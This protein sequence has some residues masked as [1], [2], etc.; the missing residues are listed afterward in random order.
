L[1]DSV[2]IILA[3]QPYQ[4]VRIL[5]RAEPPTPPAPPRFDDSNDLTILQIGSLTTLPVSTDVFTSWIG[6]SAGF[7]RDG[8]LTGFSIASGAVLE[9]GAKLQVWVIR[10][11]SE[12]PTNIFD[13]YLAQH[14]ATLGEFDISSLAPTSSAPRMTFEGLFVPVKKHDMLAIRC[15]Q[16][17][18]LPYATIKGEVNEYTDSFTASID[19]DD[20]TTGAVLGVVEFTNLNKFGHV[21]HSARVTGSTAQ[22]AAEIATEDWE[23]PEFSLSRSSAGV[24]QGNT[25]VRTLWSEQPFD[26][27]LTADLWDGLDDNGNVA[28]SGSYTIKL[29]DASGMV[30]DWLGPIGNSS[31]YDGPGWH[32][33]DIA[34]GMAITSGGKMYIAAGYNEAF[35]SMFRTTTAN[36]QSWAY[37][38]GFAHRL[39]GA[40]SFHVCTDNTK[41]YWA[42]GKPIDGITHI[43]ANNVSDDNAHTFSSGTNV[44]YS[45]RTYSGASVV[46]NTDNVSEINYYGDGLP[47]G[48][49]AQLTGDLMFLSRGILNQ[50]H[51]LNKNTGAAVATINSF[52]APTRMC[53][54]PISDGVWLVT[55]PGANWQ[56]A[57]YSVNAGTGAFTL[58]GG[59]EITSADEILAISTSPDG[60]TIRIACGGASQQI[61]SYT[62]GADQLG[63]SG[64]FA[65]ATGWTYVGSGSGLVIED[66][67]LKGNGT[68]ADCSMRFSAAGLTSGKA[69]LVEWDI[70]T[71]TGGSTSPAVIAVGTARSAVG[72]YREWRTANSNLADM[73]TF[74]FNGTVDNFIIREANVSVSTFGLAG[75]YATNGPLVAFNKF[76]F[77]NDNRITFRP[78]PDA[79]GTAWTYLAHQADG[80]LWVGDSFNRRNLRYSI[81]GT[82]FTH[83]YTLEWGASNYSAAIDPANATRVFL[84]WKEYAVD[85]SKRNGQA[86]FY[87]LVANYGWAIADD[88]NDQYTRARF[89]RTLSNGRTYCFPRSYASGSKFMEL[90]STGLRDT[91]VTVGGFTTVGFAA[92]GN[93]VRHIP[94]TTGNPHVFD[95]RQLTGFDGSNNPQHAAFANFVTSAVTSEADPKELHAAV[96]PIWTVTT[97]GIIPAYDHRKA[98]TGVHIA[99]IDASTG[100]FLWRALPSTPSNRFVQDSLPRARMTNADWAVDHFDLSPSAQSGTRCE[101]IGV[102]IIAGFNGEGWGAGQTNKYW[103]Y[104][105]SGLMAGCFGPVLEGTG[106]GQYGMAG[107]AIMWG[108]SRLDANTFILAHCDESVYGGTH[109]WKITGDISLTIHNLNVTWNAANYA[110]NV[111]DTKNLLTGLPYNASIVNGVGGWTR[112]PATDV[113]DNSSI[114]PYFIARTNEWQFDSRAG[115]TL[116]PGHTALPD[117]VVKA[118]YPSGTNTVSVTRTL[119]SVGAQW[120]LSGILQWRNADIGSA[121]SPFGY[122][123]IEILDAADKIIARLNTNETPPST[124][125][126]YGNGSSWEDFVTAEPLREFMQ[127]PKRMS[128]ARNAAGDIVFNYDTLDEFVVAPLDGTANAAVPAKLRVQMFFSA[129]GT[130]ARS[131]NF[132]ELRID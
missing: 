36:P 25:L 9:A 21:L 128:I 17:I 104:H 23:L 55:K 80:K 1:A 11:R 38:M 76:G 28:S 27:N 65:S 108:L 121:A 26:G 52:T 61:K 49:A 131:L 3:G 126:I 44:V 116:R 83:D 119:P 45:G 109:V 59:T 73:R 8:W 130:G 34:H 115:N 10:P 124:F 43:A 58:V 56:A 39:S 63:G 86:G 122:T 70:V 33:Y 129:G 22:I 14:V 132:R 79:V 77:R 51:V 31:P 106:E 15:P 18:G 53:I 69:Y 120:R 81:A 97:G 54:D 50:L 47:T 2:R 42:C 30:Y 85:Y 105:E 78:L 110:A 117:L 127:L 88:L 98:H 99:G 4:V 102:N 37:V 46:T 82:A 111:V 19:L 5:P 84:G 90:L 20:M 125:R 24:F 75:G 112:S 66:G 100:A 12:A 95:Q 35:P 41:V 113:T 118:A 57:L 60:R 67:V 29:L 114:G 32:P 48:I 7:D 87:T 103:H 96:S 13:T 68:V 62:V 101:A 16:G 89:V 107:N 92:N 94:V 6:T 93:L 74:N 40:Q 72:T 123:R 71:R 64:A 91:G